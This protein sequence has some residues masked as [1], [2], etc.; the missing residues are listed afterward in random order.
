MEWT[1]AELIK[2]LREYAARVPGK[3]SVGRWCAQQSVSK[4]AIR[5]CFSD[6]FAGLLAAADLAQRAARPRIATVDDLLAEI[7]RVATELGRPPRVADFHRLGR[8]GVSV[9]YTRVGSWRRVLELH[10]EWRQRAGAPPAPLPV[11]PPLAD[12]ADVPPSAEAASSVANASGPTQIPRT[13]GLVG[14]PLS[15]PG[16]VFAPVNEAGVVHLFGLLW[17]RHRIAVEHMG[18]AYPDCRALRAESAAAG[19]WRRISVEFELRSSNFKAHG[20]DPAQCDLIVCWEH[21]WAECPL[22]VMEL[23]QLVSNV[24][25]PDAAA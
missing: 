16:L 5:R 4:K 10:Q 15:I 21:D 2:S 18:T 22:E 13:T 3:I 14:A 20:H 19:K 9:Y 7:N 1:R 6:G 25:V 11:P 24:G 23:K 8:F 12:G 17:P